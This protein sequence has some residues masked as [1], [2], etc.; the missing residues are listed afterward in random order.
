M[1]QNGNAQNVTEPDFRKKFIFGRKCWKCAGKTG[2]LAFSQD[3]FI[4][5]FR[6]FAQRCVLAMLKTWPS[7]IFEKNSDPAENAGNMPEIAIFANFVQTFSLYFV[8]F[9]LKN[10][11]D[12]NAHH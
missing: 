4:S 11:N 7:P 12:N 1:M 2:F 6:F 5:F 10:T 8:V 3:F 9:S